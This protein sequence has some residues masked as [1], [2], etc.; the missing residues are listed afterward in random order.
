MIGQETYGV[1]VGHSKQ[2]AA[3]AAAQAALARLEREVLEG[4]VPDES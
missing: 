1:G 2:V 3:Q 4:T